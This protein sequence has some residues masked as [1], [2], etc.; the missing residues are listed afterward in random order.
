[1][2]TTLLSPATIRDRLARG[3]RAA[4]QDAL[5]PLPP[6][7]IVETIADLGSDEIA[8]VLAALPR[9]V[10]A[11]SFGY[12]EPTQQ[13][14]IARSMPRAALQTLFTGMPHDERADLWKNLPPEE[15]DAVL[16][17]LAAA[18][19]EDIRRLAAYPEGT[20]GSIMT[21]DYAT[22]APSL[23]A[24]EAI[25]V[26]RREAPDRETIYDSYVLDE[27][28]R[29]V[30]VVS[31]RDLLV[32]PAER[33]VGEIMTREVI[34]VRADD[35]KETVAQTIAE[36][37]LL[38][39]PV[40]DASD[41]MVGIVT[42]DDA[43]DAAESV[44][45]RRLTRFG[46]TASLGGPEID[47]VDSSFSQMFRARYVW[48]ALLTA[49]GLIGSIFVA[50]QEAIL[51][52]VIVLAAFIAPIIDMGGN[53]GSQ[54]AT[55]VIRAMALGQVRTV[56][57]DVLRVLRRDL[58][59]ALALGAGVAVLEVLLAFLF[60]EGILPEVLWVVGLSMLACTIAGSL[61]G[62]TIPFLAR[63]LKVDPATLSAPLITS[64][65]DLVG[66]MIYFSIAYAFLADV[67][68]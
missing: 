54:S 7:D 28:R 57:R 65:M 46:G 55:L 53:T 47:L 58:P 20:A 38:A 62:V 26:L 27:A 1:M 18:D 59:V 31:L 52:E 48:L 32:A 11:R 36:Y 2:T 61:F 40:V 34:F 67:R 29:L 23:P 68:G 66:V 50:A 51:S 13:V 25:E 56:W 44:Q 60:K 63:W 49:F 24:R 8:D 39:V 45:V 22:L 30:G 21:S 3:D 15:R 14:E 41:A 64:V 12:F 4:I 33:T 9:E 19:R 42:V 43:L 10:A 37:D 16:P 35:S 6:A 5:V 17:G